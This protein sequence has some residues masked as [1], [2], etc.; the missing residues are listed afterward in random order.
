MTMQASPSEWLIRLAFGGVGLIHLL[1]F[2]GVLGRAVLE[3]AYGVSIG[4]GSDL[5]ILM[6]HRRLVWFAGCSLFWRSDPQCLALAGGLCGAGEYAQLRVDR[7]ATAAWRAN[8]Q[9]TLD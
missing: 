6:Q 3:R 4:Q 9:D 8:Y 5:T 2:A 7:S 1:P